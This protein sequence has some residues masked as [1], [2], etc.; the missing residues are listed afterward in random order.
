MSN[1]RVRGVP[2]GKESGETTVGKV[3]LLLPQGAILSVIDCI[4]S[5]RIHDFVD[6]RLS[7]SISKDYYIGAKR[8]TQPLE[9]A[10]AL[11]LALQKS[12]DLESNGSLAQMDV[13]QFF[14][15][16]PL[17]AIAEWSKQMSFPIHVLAAI[18][19]Q[20]LAACV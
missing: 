2:T 16:L 3:R 10:F 13:E 19:R 17:R 6:T 12:L 9:I 14:D 15:T 18:L 7:P 11:Q 20:Q 5:A 1:L 8:K 4:L